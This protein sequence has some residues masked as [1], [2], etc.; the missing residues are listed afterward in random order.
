MHLKKNTTVNY[1]SLT[2]KKMVY[3]YVYKDSCG[4]DICITLKQRGFR[5]AV[6]K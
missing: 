5:F 6:E 3:K 4:I 2:F 1:N